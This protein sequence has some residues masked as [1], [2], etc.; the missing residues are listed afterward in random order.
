MKHR[1]INNLLLQPEGL[2]A[3]APDA[4]DEMLARYPYCLNLHFLAV[5]RHLQAQSPLYKTR[6]QQAATHAVD[7]TQLYAWL[8]PNRPALATPPEAE[9]LDYEEVEEAEDPQEQLAAHLDQ[10][11]SERL[12]QLQGQHGE[13]NSDQHLEEAILR[14]RNMRLG[15][16]DHADDSAQAAT[17][18]EEAVFELLSKL[19]QRL[20]LELEPQDLLGDLNYDNTPMENEVSI[21]FVEMDADEETND[22][23]GMKRIVLQRHI[24]KLRKSVDAFFKLDQTTATPTEETDRILDGIPEDMSFKEWMQSLK[25]RYDTQGAPPPSSQHDTLIDGSLEEDDEMMSEALAAILA[26]QGNWER[27]IRMYE[28]LIL[29]F[30][31][32]KAF[33][34]QKINELKQ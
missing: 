9:T 20:E 32:K 19:E 17:D 16:I 27:A 21:T 6:L 26:S 2:A 30:P 3:F 22:P 34:A 4:L 33:F 29:K 7:R 1:D 5:K 24:D 12:A 18:K 11:L 31:E 23:D 8:Y 28:Q 10:Q 14:I 25:K 15:Y 13:A